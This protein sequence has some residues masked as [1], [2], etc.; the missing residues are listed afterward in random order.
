MRRRVVLLAL[1]VG[2]AA[3]HTWPLASDPAHLSRLD[4]DDGGLNTWVVSWVAHALVSQPLQLFDAPI[5]YPEPLT[6]AYSEHMLVPS[7]MG[8]PLLWLQASPVLVYNLLVLAGF[9]LSGWAMCLLVTTWT[10]SGAGGVVAGMLYA[11][12]AHLLTRFVHLQALHVEFLPL[13][14]YAIDRVLGVAGSV[15]SSGNAMVRRDTTRFGFWLLAG[16]VLQALCSNYTLVFLA[17]ALVVAVLVRAGDWMGTGRWHRIGILMAAGAASAFILAPFLWPYYVVSR[18]QGLVRSLDEVRL[19]S[20]GV[21]DYL[22]TG[23]RLHYDAWSHRVFEGRTALFPG[24]VGLALAMTGLGGRAVMTDPRRRMMA[25]IGL[26]GVALSFGPAMPGYALLHA[27]VPLF[28]GIRGAARWGFLALTAVAVLA[29]FGVAA[30][31]N[32]LARATYRP[33]VTFLIAG[34]VTVEAL[35]A[36]MG[37]VPFE[38]IPA[39]YDR[40][41]D[42][43]PVVLAEFPLYYGERVSENAR[44]MVADT[45]GFWPLVNGYSGFESASF[46]ERAARW[47]AFPADDA[48]QAL[49]MTGVTHVMVHV[50]DVRQDVVRRAQESPSLAL[51]ADDGERR[52]Y[53]MTR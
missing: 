11:F 3:L 25:A 14:L 37:F 47:Q 23:G 15:G 19:Y 31:Q 24:F 6:L 4:N 36:P 27:S 26:M 52:L 35:R 22:T 41:N 43:G 16:F 10:G 30:L 48:V 18:D 20:A 1:F 38:G 33:A 45:R 7:V 17:A 28:S 2:L 40:L 49:R 51:V 5:F 13:A 12:N 21:L 53:R 34:L 46:R 8:A 44:Y 42:E 32:R 9:A 50:R 39:I 29:G